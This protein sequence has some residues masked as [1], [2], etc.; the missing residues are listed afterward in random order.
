MTANLDRPTSGQCENSP[1]KASQTFRFSHH[2]PVPHSPFRRDEII[3]RL[4]PRLRILSPSLE[5]P[6]DVVETFPKASAIGD[7]R[8]VFRFDNYRLITYI[9]FEYHTIYIKWLGTHDEYD[10]IDPSEVDAF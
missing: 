7:G 3:D 5:T 10:D 1:L 4:C 2:L 9:A 6:A 8:M